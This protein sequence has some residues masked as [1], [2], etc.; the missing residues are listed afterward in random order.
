MSQRRVNKFPGRGKPKDATSAEPRATLAVVPSVSDLMSFNY[1]AGRINTMDYAKA[2][3]KLIDYVGITYLNVDK[4]LSTNRD[5][6]I[7][8]PD[9]P[10]ILGP[11]PMGL[12]HTAYVE[13]AKYYMRQRHSLAED[14]KK[15]FSLVW[16]LCSPPL[17]N[18]IIAN[19]QNRWNAVNSEKNLVALWNSIE[20]LCMVGAAMRQDPIQRSIDGQVS[21]SKVYQ[22]DDETLGEFY[23]RY[24]DGLRT[25]ELTGNTAL[26]QPTQAG[27]FLRRL[28]KR[29]YGSLLDRLENDGVIGYMGNFPDTLDEAYRVAAGYKIGGKLVAE[30]KP[31]LF[32]QTESVFATMDKHRKPDNKKDS[33]NSEKPSD[34][35]KEKGSRFRPG[36]CHFCKKPGHWR[37]ECPSLLKGKQSFDSNNGNSSDEGVFCLINGV[38]AAG[39][40]TLGKYDILLD[41]QA[42]ISIF[43]EKSMLT[44]IRK[45]DNPVEITG[46]GGKLSV[47]L[48]GDFENI[49][50]VYYHP[51]CVANILSFFDIAEN[52]DVSYNRRFNQFTVC[53]DDRSAIF[54]PFGKLYVWRFLNDQEHI[55]VNTVE[56]NKTK[57]TEREIKSAKKARDLRAKLGYPSTKDLK[58]L[59]L[60]SQGASF[61]VT[62]QDL[63]N[64]IAIWGPDLGSLKGKSTRRPTEHVH[65]DRII[66]EINK[67]V[68]LCLD[69]F[70]CSWRSFH[71]IR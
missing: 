52:H 43:K 34:S 39:V 14:K 12:L 56:D 29:V 11:D 5:Y 2:K 42:T 48:I 8:I 47:N 53:I 61:E 16:F 6:E 33:V 27:I 19:L 31:Q 22:R 68:V 38:M 15:V 69:I 71:F 10:Q 62:P 60:S 46:I 13:E 70:F 40:T 25:Y 67:D 4:I 45:A 17:Q 66:P 50:K 20:E 26:D 28:N 24:Q 21:F 9:F 3:K 32:V 35:E 59:L 63:C 65:V 55:Y 51:D 7:P 58:E 49:T 44:N 30:L 64:A 41:N 23:Q 36:K 18:A 1:V 37:K 57:F 54:K